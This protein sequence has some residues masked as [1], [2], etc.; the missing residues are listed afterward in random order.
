MEFSTQNWN[1]SLYSRAENLIYVILRNSYNFSIVITHE[2]NFSPAT[3][4][5]ISTHLLPLGLKIQPWVE[6]I[7]HAYSYWQKTCFYQNRY[8]DWKWNYE[9]SQIQIG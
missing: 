9:T 1:F 5:E 6:N 2:E 8:G 7:I 3:R 4:V